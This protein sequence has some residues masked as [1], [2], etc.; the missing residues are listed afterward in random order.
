ML[1]LL[2]ALPTTAIA[3]HKDG[4]QNCTNSAIC[5]YVEN[6]P[7]GGGSQPTQPTGNGGGGG[8]GGGTSNGG[9][10]DAPQ[11]AS[12]AA[13]KVA[14]AGPAG[15]GA[16]SLANSTAPASLPNVAGGSGTGGQIGPPGGEPTSTE[17]GGSPGVGTAFGHVV[18]AWDA[19][20]GMGLALPILMALTLVAA[21]LIALR[22][23]RAHPA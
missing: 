17:T 6:V 15:A 9:G 3:G 7:G 23:R 13:E 4:G 10:G 22:R 19:G 18:G 20:S 2:L 1:V 5:Q 21:I 12:P 8:G 14:A 16:A 11:S